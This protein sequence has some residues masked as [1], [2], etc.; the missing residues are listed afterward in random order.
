MTKVLMAFLGVLVM[1]SVAFAAYPANDP[2]QATQRAQALT[3]VASSVK[4][5][6]RV[7]S[8]TGVVASAQPG[9][10]VVTL[11]GTVSSTDPVKCPVSYFGVQD[12]TRGGFDPESGGSGGSGGAGD[13][14]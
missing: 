10:K 9:E 12:A 2:C 14:D 7:A 4:P 11:T 13:A 3:S 1:A 6:Q 8:L 5:D